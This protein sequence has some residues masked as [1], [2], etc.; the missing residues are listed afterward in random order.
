MAYWHSPCF[1]TGSKMEQPSPDPLR[2]F[3]DALLEEQTTLTA[4]E[5]FAREHDRCEIPAGKQRYS[6]LLPATAPGPGQ[7]YAFEVDM[8]KCSGCKAC[9][10]ACHS[11]NGLDDGEAWRE[12]GTLVSHDW[13]RPFRQT[14][15][16][17]CHHCVD[18]G[19]LNGCPVPAYEK[20]AGTGIVQHLDDQC[21]GC[22]YCVMMCPYNVPKY[23]ERRG[24]VRK[25][26]LCSQR[27]PAG[28]APACVQACPSEAIRI[29]VV[30]LAKVRGKFRPLFNNSTPKTAG[31][32]AGKWESGKDALSHF[33]AFPSAHFP[34]EN[35][36]A[37][38]THFSK[39]PPTQPSICR[40]HA[41]SRH[42]RCPSIPEPPTPHN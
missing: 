42:V 30:E 4:V 29:I 31:G 17:A 23:S 34:S 14:I 9:V 37:R 28:E 20:D 26:D 35:E 1:E 12:T 13:R 25:C 5:R 38:G 11:L 10:T 6:S 39:P 18:P 2:K 15:T 7:Q 27:L 32:K 16:T 41:S 8:D 19:C 40:T 21:I 33:L 36:A 24:I 22:E 3:I